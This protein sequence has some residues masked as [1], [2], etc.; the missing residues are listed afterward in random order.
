M[1]PT[2]PAFVLSFTAALAG[3]ASDPVA[4]S[5]PDSGTPDSGTPDSGTA[6]LPPRGRVAV[7]AWLASGAYRMWHCEPT[8]H[9]ARSPSPHGINRICSNAALSAHAGSGEYPVGSA[10]V[11]ELYD[12]AGTAVV[13]YAVYTHVSAGTMGNNWYWYERV[14]LTSGAPHDANGTVADGIGDTGPAASICVGCHAAT[15]VDAMHSGHD[16]VYTQ[17]H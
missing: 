3:C 11:K 7:E 9:A 1:R 4:T 8:P 14:P 15:G 17:V 13:G 5:T 16:F 12:A 10:A 2:V 6:Q